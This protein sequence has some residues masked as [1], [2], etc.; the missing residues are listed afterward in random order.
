MAVR[1][2]ALGGSD[3]MQTTGN[4]VRSS[5]PVRPEKT[6]DPEM[7]IAR[8]FAKRMAR[9]TE[10]ADRI[11]TERNVIAWAKGQI[12]TWKQYATLSKGEAGVPLERW[13]SLNWAMAYGESGNFLND[14]DAQRAKNAKKAMDE[15][16]SKRADLE[17]PRTKPN[18]VQRGPL[19]SLP[20]QDPPFFRG[21]EALANF[22]AEHGPDPR[23]I[24]WAR[25]QL[26]DYAAYLRSTAKSLN[27]PM[28][29]R[30]WLE[31]NFKAERRTR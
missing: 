20:Y 27:Q 18:D 3:D 15:A 23:L 19:T 30:R 25:K 1:N 12:D 31:I 8:D 5:A 11:E 14:L 16:D 7:S 26:M 29:A 6:Y 21:G 28:T 17:V 9:Q 24:A 2:T 22:R 10:N 13:L 4:R